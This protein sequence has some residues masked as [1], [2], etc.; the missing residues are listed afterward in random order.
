[1][2][3]TGISR[4]NFLGAGELFLFGGVGCLSFKSKGKAVSKPKVVPYKYGFD[5][6]Y[7]SLAGGVTYYGHR[8][9]KGP[10]S[11]TRHRNGSFIEEEGHATDLIGREVVRSIHKAADSPNPFFM[12]L[13]IFDFP[14]CPEND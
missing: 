8:Y 9:K 10:Y 7:G 5:H 12:Y 6:S 3:K 2:R 13:Q 1:M 14:N 4:R 11:K